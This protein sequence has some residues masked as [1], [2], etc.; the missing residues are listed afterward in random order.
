MNAEVTISAEHV[1][2][3]FGPITALSDVTLSVY[4]GE[5]F[6]FLGPN[7]SG[8]ST[9]I[10][11]LCG[12]LE[13]TRGRAS[14]LGYDSTRQAETVKALLGYMPQQFSLYPDL[15]V[16]E[17]LEFFGSLYGLRGGRLKAR[18]GVVA[19]WLHLLPLYPQLSGTL[20]SGWK[21]RLSLAC[22]LLHDPPVLFLDEPTSGI[23]PVTRA[24]M[25]NLLFEL[26]AQGKTLFVTTHYMDEAGRCNRLGY[27]YNSR[28]LTVGTAEEL[29][30]L[31]GVTPE[32]ARWRDFHLPGISQHLEQVRKIP[33]VLAAS[34]YGNSAHLLVVN[35]LP[36]DG[37]KEHLAQILNAEIFLTP[38]QP[39]VEDVFIFLSR[40]GTKPQG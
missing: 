8:K 22:A 35:D 21:K 14:V 38:S 5:V 34:A 27:I 24:E 13:P 23:D 18:I 37:L 2:R 31:A 26:S 3:S 33:G 9:L 25:W 16:Y 12:M 19:E 36:D 28:L 11:I 20:S 40:V 7:G 39:N 10:R 30:L 17:N 15:T 29:T 6:G 32:N 1:W 4:R